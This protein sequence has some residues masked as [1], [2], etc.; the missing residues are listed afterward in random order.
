MPTNKD[1]ATNEENKLPE[2]IEVHPQLFD[3][4]NCSA[5]LPINH[6]KQRTLFWRVSALDIDVNMGELIDETMPPGKFAHQGIGK[7]RMGLP[8]GLV[9]S[10][11]AK[12]IKIKEVKINQG[13][14]SASADKTFLPTGSVAREAIRNAESIPVSDLEKLENGTMPYPGEIS[15]GGKGGALKLTAKAMEVLMNNGQAYARIIKADGTQEGHALVTLMVKTAK[16]SLAQTASTEIRIS[17]D[18]EAPPLKL[19]TTQKNYLQG[20]L[21]ITIRYGQEAVFVVPQQSDENDNDPNASQPTNELWTTLNDVKKEE[22][23][24]A[25]RKA[26]E[27][28]LQK[29][30]EESKRK[31]QE[32]K[33]KEGWEAPFKALPRYEIGLATA[34]SQKWTLLGYERGSLVGSISL[35]PG[36]EATVEVFSWEKM[37]EQKD[38]ESTTEFERNVEVGGLGRTT[39]RIA[40]DAATE[41]GTTMNAGGQATVPIEAVSLGANASGSAET[42]INTNVQSGI[43]RVVEATSKSATRFQM[44]HQ[45][46]ISHTTDRGKETRATRR[47][48]NPNP[49]R[50]LEFLHFEVCEQHKVVTQIE[51]PPK[52]VVFVENPS[53]GAFEIPVVFANEHILKNVL[54]SSDYKEGF[55][56]ARILHAQS[57]FESSLQKAEELATA[58]INK[59]PASTQI[60][61]GQP[62][63]GA[64]NTGIY[65]TARQI[66]KVLKEFISIDLADE[67]DILIQNLDPFRAK[68]QKPSRRRVKT[69]DARFARWSYW[70]KFTMAYPGIEDK[71]ATFIDVQLDGEDHASEQDV[72][73]ALQQLTDGLDDDWLTAIKMVVGAA[74][75]GV[76][77]SLLSG[78]AAGILQPFIIGLLLIS[79]DMGLPAAITRARR[80]LPA[81]RALQQGQEIIEEPVPVSTPASQGPQEIVGPPKIFTD[82]E[83]ALAN[84]D[85]EKLRLHL[86]KNRTYYENAIWDAEDPNDRFVRLEATGVAKYVENIILGYVGNRAMYPLRID[87]L[88]P[89]V[90]DGIKSIC[91]SVINNPDYSDNFPVAE[92]Y[93]SIPRPAIHTEAYVGTCDL[94]EPY[95]RERRAID[96]RM[97][98]AT[99]LQEEAK[100]RQ[101]SIEIDR[102]RARLTQ[103]PP[104]L[105]WPY[106]WSK[107][108]E[109]A[110]LE[111][112]VP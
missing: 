90:A 32:A 106:G 63:A 107:D 69:A 44:T 62:V 10:E 27:E 21:P 70:A 103:T 85:F 11:W 41:L 18:K 19:T 86:E 111:S 40:I 67:A 112:D 80:E 37:Q 72:I 55:S 33:Q 28:A 84:A 97:H 15:G 45:V 76:A 61:D 68:D 89:E 54:L 60:E 34:I 29:A 79:D 7:L 77:L 31:T 92:K 14:I 2:K 78:P 71:A 104:R 108:R 98:E 3:P 39:S 110:D 52:L 75:V 57:W 56:A 58:S 87:A 95:M 49:G 94:L 105:E 96:L 51:G 102:L 82:S 22:L 4:E 6:I 50:I 23:K 74:V 109:D 17:S 16:V 83:L 43:D 5:T 101:G 99:A 47:I 48:K 8:L 38:E 100:A 53:I 42:Q 93:Y 25:K 1:S 12:R 46:K 20:G 65:Q 73:S 35:E 59:T 30:K 24:E 9:A 66:Q 81:E 88:T 64:P 13:T 36:A 91:G 26:K